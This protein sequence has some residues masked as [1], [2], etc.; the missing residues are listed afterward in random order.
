MSNFDSL[1]ERFYMKSDNK[2]YQ[3]G[4]RIKDKNV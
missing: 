2:I 1:S 4:Q 3:A